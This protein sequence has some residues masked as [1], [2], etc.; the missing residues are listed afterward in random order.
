MEK[1]K[2][3]IAVLSGGLDSTVA[4]SVFKE[5]YDI[6]AVTFNYGQR[7]VDEEINSARVIC[8]KL[9]FKHTIID[10]KWLKDLGSSALTTDK[11]LPILKENQLDDAKLTNESA[12][13]VWVPGRNVVFTSIALSFAE[14]EGA[15]IIIVGWDK[16]EAATFPDNSKEFLKSFNELINIGSIDDIEI[17]APAIDLTKKEIVELGEKINAPMELSYSCYSGEKSHCGICE[18]CLR[19]KRAFKQADILDKTKYLE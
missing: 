14:S 18:S 10:L 6:H 11:D 8:D 5:D 1:K 13:N 9:G 2:K 12:L 19:R 3:G 17:K 7:A 16:E 15:E 4:V